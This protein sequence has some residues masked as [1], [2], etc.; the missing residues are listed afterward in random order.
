[1]RSMKEMIFKAV[2]YEG[3]LVKMLGS[4]PKVERLHFVRE[5]GASKTTLLHRAEFSGNVQSLKVIL[6]LY[7][8]SECCDRVIIFWMKSLAYGT[9]CAALDRTQLNVGVKAPK[10][11]FFNL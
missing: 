9:Y 5:L 7:P 4:V 8:E 1:M 6:N 10:I 11:T 3:M 2:W